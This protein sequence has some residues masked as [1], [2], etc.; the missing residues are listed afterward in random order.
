MYNTYVLMKDNVILSETECS[1]CETA[2]EEFSLDYP[3]YKEGYQVKIK[4]RPQIDYDKIVL[5]FKS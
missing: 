2:L 3:I 5:R 1:H 4:P